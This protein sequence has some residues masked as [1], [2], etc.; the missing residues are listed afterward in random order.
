MTPEN[1]DH[2]TREELI[3]LILG[4]AQEAA[5]LKASYAQ[6]QADYQALQLQLEKLQ[7]DE[8]H[9]RPP[10][11]P[12]T[13]QNSSQPPS[14]DQKGNLAE[15]RSG[16]KRGAQK[17]HPKHERRFVARPDQVVELKAVCCS[18]CQSDLQ[19]QKA[20]L[21]DVTQITE[22]P[23]ARAQVIEVRQYETTCAH[24]GQVHR[25]EP[26]AGLELER[27]WGARLEATV[28]YYRQE[29]HMS[30][31]RTQAAL[32]DLH[33]VEISEGG[34]DQI[35]QRAGQRAQP[36]AESIQETVRQAAVINSDETGARLDGRTWWQWVFCTAQAVLHVIQPSRGAQVIAAVMG[37][38]KAQVWGS[39]CLPA[40]LKAPAQQRQICLAHQLRDLQGVID[41]YPQSVWSQAMRALFRA[42]IH[43]HH[44]RADLPPDQ[45]QGQV[46]RLERLCDRL[47]KRS[48]PQ[49]EA[50]R[51]QK[52]Y[53]KH[54]DSLFVFLYRTDVEPTNNVAER[55]L[56]SSV[57]HRKV[58]NGFRSEWGAKA[59]A[60]LASVIDTAALKGQTPFAAILALMGQPALSP[61][62]AAL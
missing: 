18:T 60:A 4:Q 40:Q 8:R 24:C 51:L 22:L 7:A 17:G 3:V 32:H 34:I 10:K 9:P 49:P 11:P 38:G 28:V 21:V 62:R 44:Q 14:R 25:P 61:S 15:E 6:L 29:Q 46:A 37:E 1:L 57:V 26:P 53:L 19:E 12:T 50:V 33:Q 20:I 30:Y 59:Y 45:F 43:L 41:C 2:L 56:R 48:P 52:R 36:Q 47:L 55:A 23:E 31:V 5:R 16:R 35:M 27:T 54:R 58:T 39:D 13:S 42:A